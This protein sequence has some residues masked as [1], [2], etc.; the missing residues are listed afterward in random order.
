MKY[1][2]MGGI[3]PGRESSVADSG[4]THRWIALGGLGLYAFGVLSIGLTRD[5]RLRNE[6][7]GAM[8]TTL[9]LSHLRLGLAQTRGHDLFYSPHTG[10]TIP[11]GHHP[12]A[13]ALV[14]AGAFALTGSDSPRRCATERHRRSSLEACSCSR[15]SRAVL[16]DAPSAPGGIR[17]GHAADERLLRPNGELR[18]ALPLRHP[19]STLRLC[20]IQA[21]GTK[22]RRWSGFHWGSSGAGW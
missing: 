9:A 11:Y 7:N 6:D 21:N 1:L 13:T 17:D 19:R 4:M 18:T 15:R 10:Q 22:V 16:R 14:L 8:H 5:W 3:Y 20:S 2:C 12:P